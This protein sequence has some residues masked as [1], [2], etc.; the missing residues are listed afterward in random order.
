VNSNPILLTILN[1]PGWAHSAALAYA[2]VYEKLCRGGDVAEH[3]FLQCSDVARRITYLDTADS[4]ATEVKWFDGRNH[5]WENGFWDA[6]QHSS[7][8]KEALLLMA[9]RIQE[10]DF[11][12]S[13][14]VLQWL[15]SSELRMEVPDAFQV[16]RLQRIMPKPLRSSASTSG[17]LEADFPKKT[18]T[19]SL[20]V[21]RPTAPLPSSGIVNRSR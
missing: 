6:I 14:G 17:C 13:T 21:K 11:E 1:D 20:R 9:A 7:N 16:E 10:S 12:T 5:G 18:R 8:P 19:Y 4:L 2:G 3:R 15:A